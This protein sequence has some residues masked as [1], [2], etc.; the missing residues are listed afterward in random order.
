MAPKSSKVTV[1]I[2]NSH[3]FTSIDKMYY[4]C[5][6]HSNITYSTRG[7]I[8]AWSWIRNTARTL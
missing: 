2:S 6:G 7:Y 1:I 5:D 4:R 3:L 8:P